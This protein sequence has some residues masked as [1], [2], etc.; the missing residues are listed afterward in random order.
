MATKLSPEKQAILTKDFL[1]REYHV[2]KKSTYTIAKENC[3]GYG[4]V[5]RSFRFFG[6]RRR[7]ST[8]CRESVSENL[9]KEFLSY[10]YLILKK[11][12]QKLATELGLSCHRKTESFSRRL[13]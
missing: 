13:D 6:I 8:Q 10:Q 7:K 9:T 11:S 2:L 5:D 12:Q 3:I 1:Y 4:T